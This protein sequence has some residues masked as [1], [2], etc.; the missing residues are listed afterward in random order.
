MR[1]NHGNTRR[2]GA[3][4]LNTFTPTV[5]ATAVRNRRGLLREEIEKTIAARQGG[6]ARPEPGVRPRWQYLPS[7][8]T[9]TGP[10]SGT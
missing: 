7:E 8:S 2:N 10:Y 3:P 1:L 4:A 6:T 5:A 9:L